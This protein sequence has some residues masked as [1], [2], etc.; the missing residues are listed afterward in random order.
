MRPLAARIRATRPALRIGVTGTR[1]LPTGAALV[2]LRAAVARVFDLTEAAARR[3]RGAEFWIVSPLAEGAD[4]FVAAIAR[5]R[6]YRLAVPL[7]FAPAEYEKDFSAEGLATFRTLLA[8]ARRVT[9]HRG[10]R[11]AATQAYEAA[12]RAVVRQADLMIAIWDGQPARGRG[13]TAEIVAYAARTGVPVAWITPDGAGPAWIARGHAG[14]APR[15][16][17]AA[18]RLRRHVRACFERRV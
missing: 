9:S 18:T 13:G 17:A 7:P 4:Q 8:A 3:G 11:T 15:G 2:A 12:G 14:T 16:R 6:G 1:R 5:A 10:R